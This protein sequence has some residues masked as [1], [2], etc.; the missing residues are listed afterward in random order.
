[1][2]PF[3]LLRDLGDSVLSCSCP[4][5]RSRQHINFDSSAKI[6]HESSGW[7]S[8]QKTK[9]KRRIVCGLLMCLLPVHT[10]E[11]SVEGCLSTS[12]DAAWR[13][14]KMHNTFTISGRSQDHSPPS[15]CDDF[16]LER[17]DSMQTLPGYSRFGS[18]QVYT[19]VKKIF[20]CVHFPP[21]TFYPTDLEVSGV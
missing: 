12:K 20:S 21:S 9:T 7:F 3:V 1:M 16:S 5:H 18:N 10:E 13:T 8:T 6:P 17:T 4:W 19:K 2:P 14:N 11:S 15:C